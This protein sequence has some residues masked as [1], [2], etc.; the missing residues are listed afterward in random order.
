[1]LSKTKALSY[2]NA[3]GRRMAYAPDDADVDDVLRFPYAYEDYDGEDIRERLAKL[4]P[5]NMWVIYHSQLLKEEKAR[6]PEQFK[7]ERWYSKDFTTEE[8]S[9]DF[10]A[11][12][13]T[14]MP[15]EGM[16]MGNAPANKFMPK[17]ENLKAAKLERADP[18]K[19]GL[20]KR[21]DIGT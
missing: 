6:N 18:S 12:L 11:H 15:E 17:A 14:A 4:V 5:E 13:K 8:L 2:A 9:A 7:Q 19:P 10:K 1:M 20:P 3:I 16:K 21:I